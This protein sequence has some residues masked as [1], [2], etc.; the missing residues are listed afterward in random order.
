MIRAEGQ[1]LYN[2]VSFRVGTSKNKNTAHRERK[3]C[4]PFGLPIQNKNSAIIISLLFLLDLF[5]LIK[6]IRKI[7]S[8]KVLI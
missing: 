1:P 3:I 4:A 8:Q 6:N 7:S 5:E 2:I